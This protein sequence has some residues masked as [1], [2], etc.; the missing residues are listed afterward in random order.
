MGKKA[1]AKKFRM[2]A[3]AAQL[4]VVFDNAV[5]YHY[6]KG[7]ELIDMNYELPA[8][9][10][11]KREKI[12]PNK[13]YRFSMPVQVAANHARRMRRAYQRNGYE[14]VN[15]YVNRVV[16]AMN[17]TNDAKA[18]QKKPKMTVKKTDGMAKRVT[19]IKNFFRSIFGASN[20]KLANG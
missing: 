13:D 6:Y 17:K 19:E 7:Q 12:V 20:A 15:A 11:G 8:G 10:D 4:P 1:N 3:A 14:G 18:E 16:A 5:E 9:E 2:L